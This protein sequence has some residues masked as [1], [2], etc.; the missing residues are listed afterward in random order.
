MFSKILDLDLKWHL[1]RKTGEVTRILDR[2]TSAIQ[3]TLS[4]GAPGPDPV[5]PWS[6]G[7]AVSC[8]MPHALFLGQREPACL[9]CGGMRHWRPQPS[10]LCVITLRSASVPDAREG[11]HTHGLMVPVTGLAKSQRGC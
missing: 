1:L 5:Q 4:T 6:P 8:S 11:S 9:R 7:L 10:L 2:G 3:N